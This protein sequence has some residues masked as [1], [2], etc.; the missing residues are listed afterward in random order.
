[1][2]EEKIILTMKKQPLASE[3]TEIRKKR[4]RR[5]LLIV[6][7]SFLLSFGVYF[8]YQVAKKDYE[9]MTIDS[10]NTL[11]EIEYLLNNYWL[12]ANEYDDLNRD[13]EDKAFYGMSIFEDDPYTT[14]MSKK[15]IDEF[16]TS[17]NMDYVGIGLQYTNYNDISTVDK[18]FKDSPAE[19]AGVLAGD[20]IKAI[21]GESVDGLQTS[22]IKDKIIGEEGSEVIV[23]FQRGNDLLDI[24]IIRGS[25]DS[26]V[27]C[28]VQDDYV[29]M[30]LNSFGSETAK[31]IMNYLDQ[32][33]NYNKIIIDLRGNSGGYQSA[34]EEIAG[35]FI[36]D[37][38][39]YMKQINKDG[40]ETIDKTKCSKT[41]DNFEKIVIL[42]D[43]ST[44]S[45]A[46]V[47]TICLKEQFE[48][49]TTVG[50]TTYGKGVVQ[51]TFTLSDGSSLK[52]TST[53]WLSPNGLWINKTGIKPDYEIKL[54]EVMY[55]LIYVM[56]EDDKYEIDSVSEYV[57]LA[58]KCLQFLEYDV[59]RTDGYFD[60]SFKQALIS[61]KTKNNLG[62]DA[63]LDKKT[64]DFI[65]SEVIHLASNNPQY[66]TQMLKAIDLLHE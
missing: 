10:V 55:E 62:Q 52:V 31:T 66:D 23:T 7:C 4:L 9:S 44:A 8:G 50:L 61:Y 36:G 53:K 22:E 19:K 64:Y 5:I 21:N 20:I 54:P 13:L 12:Y 38:Q 41:Y 34:V 28:Y 47:L 33:T 2:E 3:R 18:V 32:Y 11:G 26:S 16:S 1:M 35:L 45:A 39:V 43:S 51:T 25:V 27:Y 46:E 49:C 56:A 15:E 60:E 30:E 48:D 58:E 65:Y 57:K 14:Y 29:I 17:I 6:L 24:S 63:I 42:T 37:G 59:D 40:K